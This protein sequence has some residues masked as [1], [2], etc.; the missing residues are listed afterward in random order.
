MDKLKK[1][2]RNKVQEGNLEA[3]RA[4]FNQLSQLLDELV[5]PPHQDLVNIQRGIKTCLWLQSPNCVKVKE[6]EL[7]KKR[8]EQYHAK[9]K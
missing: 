1:K 3:T 8:K 4:L 5:L 2:I 7:L 9:Q 6:D